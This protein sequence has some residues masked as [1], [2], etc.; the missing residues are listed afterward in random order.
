M[1]IVEQLWY[2]G[3]DVSPMNDLQREQ[4]QTKIINF[5]QKQKHKS[6]VELL[7]EFHGFQTI[8]NGYAN[9]NDNFYV[10]SSLEIALRSRGAFGSLFVILSQYMIGSYSNAYS[11]FKE[12]CFFY[13]NL[14]GD[15]I[16]ASAYAKIL[17]HENILTA[18][19]QNADWVKLSAY[20]MVTSESVY[21]YHFSW[22]IACFLHMKKAGEY[23]ADKVVGIWKTCCEFYVDPGR[24]IGAIDCYRRFGIMLAIGYLEFT[25]VNDIYSYVELDNIFARCI[26]IEENSSITELKDLGIQY[27]SLSYYNYR[28]EL[29]KLPLIPLSVSLHQIVDRITNWSKKTLS[30]TTTMY[31]LEASFICVVVDEG[32]SITVSKGYGMLPE[33]WNYKTLQVSNNAQEIQSFPHDIWIRKLRDTLFVLARKNKI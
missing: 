3:L 16:V 8:S 2:F 14:N 12:C 31:K 25:H 29:E 6:T 32:N 13:F 28:S 5:L 4:V 18:F 19:L 30:R 21:S 7:A 27:L 33:T 9:A 26:R 17:Q 22:A 24:K 20:F 10:P 11:K 23:T 15:P 1:G